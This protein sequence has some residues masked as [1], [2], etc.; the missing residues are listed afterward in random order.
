MAKR[1]VLEDRIIRKNK[2]PVLIH[3]KEW[4]TLFSENMSKT[5]KKKV[6][7][8]EEKV[9]EEKQA[10]IQ[11]KSLKKQKKQLMDKIIQLSDDVNSNKKG[12]NINSLELTKQQILNSNEKID[13]LQ[14]K[15]ETLPK[16]IEQLNLELLK[17]TIHLA[18]SDIKE[19]TD[20]NT[21]LTDEI[22]EL[23]EKLHTKWEE[24]IYWEKK[25]QRLCILIYTLH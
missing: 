25:E 21:V 7:E 3:S 19:G 4:K 8:L 5:M 2:I 6:Q 23:R 14:Y 20:K 13:E 16:E 10:F 1:I 9:E 24:K 12:S 11:I 22:A 18:Y 15:L 17:E